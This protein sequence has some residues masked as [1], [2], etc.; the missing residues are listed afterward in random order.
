MHLSTTYFHL[1]TAKFPQT[2]LKMNWWSLQYSE[3]VQYLVTVTSLVPKPR[4]LETGSLILLPHFPLQNIIQFFWLYLPN[5][6]NYLYLPSPQP[7]LVQAAIIYCQKYFNDL[8]D[9][10]NE[11][12]IHNLTYWSIICLYYWIYQAYFSQ[13]KYIKLLFYNKR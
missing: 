3:S 12:N 8:T 4:N 9:W 13:L 5:T 2:Q 6:L 7:I 11:G 1:N 10:L